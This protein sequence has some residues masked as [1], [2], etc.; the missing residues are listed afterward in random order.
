M[1]KL[2]IY[3]GENQVFDVADSVKAISSMQGVSNARSGRFIGAI[4]E[5]DYTFNEQSTIVRIT[6]DA[7]TVTVEGLGEESLDFAIRLQSLLPISLSAIDLEYSFNINLLDYNSVAE[8]R[9]AIVS[10]TNSFK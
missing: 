2:L 6:D 4:F 9:Q 5:C 1:S 8:L 10:Y 3:I 7:E